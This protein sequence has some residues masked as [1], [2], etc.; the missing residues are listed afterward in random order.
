M[1][2]L[3]YTVTCKTEKIFTFIFWNGHCYV[4]ESNHFNNTWWW[5]HRY[6]RDHLRLYIWLKIFT[7]PTSIGWPLNRVNSPNSGC[8]PNTG[9]RPPTQ[10]WATL[11]PLAALQTNGPL[12][13]LWPNYKLMGRFAA[14]GLTIRWWAALRPIF[15]M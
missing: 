8:L 11:R 7:V 10:W 6:S 5:L 12:C 2:W 3:Y 9:Y 14:L 4:P 15:D 13:R 1:L